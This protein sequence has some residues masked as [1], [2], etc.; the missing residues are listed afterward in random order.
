MPSCSAVGRG[1]CGPSSAD[2]R[3]HR[4]GYAGTMRTAADRSS[5]SFRRLLAAEVEHFLGDARLG[6][7]PRVPAL[8]ELII[9]LSRYREE[10]A[11]LYPEVFVVDDLDAALP[12]L[13]GFDPVNVGRCALDEEGVRRAIK[14]TAPVGRVGWSIYF[15]VDGT[16]FRYGFFRSDGFVLAPSAMDRLRALKDDGFHALGVTQLEENVVEIRAANGAY[17]HVF[18]S[19]ARVDASPRPVV[20]DRLVGTLASDALPVVRDGVRNFWRRCLVDSQR[21]AHGSLLAVVRPEAAGLAQFTDAAHLTPPVDVARYV[22]TYLERRDE[23]ARAA[24]YAAATLASGMLGADGIT[25]V[26]RDGAVLAYN[27]FVRHREI[28]DGVRTGGAG[29]ARRRTFDALAE[30]V[31]RTLIAAFYHSQDGASDVATEA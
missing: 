1:S 21:L 9:L 23:P 13:Q 24:V 29:G 27:A 28:R 30:E 3:V 7:D 31:G 6:F 8:C 20:V 12:R 4:L 10:G 11:S 16:A 18:L 2:A 5:I 25:V 22:A 19:G 15:H 17:R 14:R 26:R